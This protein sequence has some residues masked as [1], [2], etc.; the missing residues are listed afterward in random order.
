MRKALLICI[1][2]LL[3]PMSACSSG[4]TDS[5]VSESETTAVQTT[6][7]VV[8]TTEA[9]T[10]A[11]TETVT[12]ETTTAPI[13]TISLTEVCDW[14][15]S[16][17]WNDGFC[18]ISHYIEDG[19]NSVGETMDIEFT[20]SN[21]SIALEKK[22]QYNDY[23]MSLDDSSSQVGQL[24]NAWA[25]MCEQ[26]DVLHNQITAETPRPADF[27]YEFDAVLF[28][29]YY[30]SFYDLCMEIRKSDY[31]TIA[32][33]TIELVTETTEST[34]IGVDN[35][36]R[37]TSSYEYVEAIGEAIAIDNVAVMFAEM[38][39]AID[40]TAFY[41]NG[42]KFEIYQFADNAAELDEAAA[43]QFTITLEGFGDYT[44]LSSV[45][46]NYILIY[47]VEDSAV[48]QAFLET[49]F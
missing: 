7:P 27:S 2:C 44:L 22:S 14:V 15:T 4:G 24:Q 35:D 3:V 8:E 38:I 48:K 46:G 20:I 10:V 18:D 9:T 32:T 21:L 17:I 5:V 49:E 28:K 26:I 1:C 42:N 19:K 41:Y 34:T 11:T 39:G 43:G 29:Q 13:V 31:Q 47:N 45:N 37:I 33:D 25:K 40:G 12:E 36:L 16:D 23:V 30:N 6:A